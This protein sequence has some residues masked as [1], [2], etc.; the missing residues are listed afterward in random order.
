[1]CRG[2]SRAGVGSRPPKVLYT[3]LR[4]DLLN[5]LLLEPSGSKFFHVRK[6]NKTN[7][8]SRDCINIHAHGVRHEWLVCGSAW[9]S[10]QAALCYSGPESLTVPRRKLLAIFCQG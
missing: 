2:G 3:P 10:F 4:P 5:V 6:K 7:V 8:C 1:M 9:K